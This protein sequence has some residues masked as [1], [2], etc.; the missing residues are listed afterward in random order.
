M[1]LSSTA[2]F[3][4]KHSWGRG[5]QAN[6]KTLIE[7]PNP[8]SRADLLRDP[9]LANVSFFNR[10]TP[11]GQDVLKHWEAIKRSLVDHNPRAGI[12]NALAPYKAKPQRV[13]GGPTR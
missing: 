1:E 10:P 12:V 13:V 4:R 5:F 7:I 3:D 9:K 2:E 8:V 6:L 11:L